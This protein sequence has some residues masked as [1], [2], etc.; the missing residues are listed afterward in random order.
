MS[1]V[2]TIGLDLAKQFFQ[3]HG[4]DCRGHVV[5]QKKLTRQNLLRFFA[6]LPQCIVGME[7]C[8]G[9]HHWA[10]ELEK[11][12]HTPKLMPAQY[13]KPYVKTNKN[14][15]ADA[16]A[17]CEAV[18]RPNMR[19]VA[20]K[21]VEQQEILALH[22]IRQGL[23]KRRTA[24]VNETRGLLLEFGIALPQGIGNVRESL[25]R[26]VEDL[27]NGLTLIQRDTFSD[28]YNELVE[29]DER[30]GKLER[31]LKVFADTSESCQR[32]LKVPGLG[33]L[34]VT[35]LLA[36]VGKATC[37]K[38]GRELAAWLGIVPR[39][40]SSGGKDRLLGI[41][42]RGDVYLRLLLIHGARAVLRFCWRKEDERSLWLQRLADRR[43]PHKA[44]V[45]QANKTVRICWA[46][47]ARN[48][49]YR[50]AC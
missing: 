31:Q 35:A 9:A 39:Q 47:L 22:R 16:E 8:G 17:I 19:F 12:G 7:A 33:V 24:L 21:S 46:I 15:R 50:Q 26:L 38:N 5:L 10:R 11:L 27:Y 25:P 20:I 49:E 44:L 14:D 48:E 41:S 13:V 37:F 34:T 43:G 28:L 32:L 36:T 18:T 45:A 30:V 40:H 2:C 23:I 6:K 29:I 4:V 42:K 1:A 3:M